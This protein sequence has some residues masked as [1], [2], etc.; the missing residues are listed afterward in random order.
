MTT[1]S[2][3]SM[4]APIG[5]QLLPDQRVGLRSRAVAYRVCCSQ[6]SVII[7]CMALGRADV[8]NAAVAMLNVVPLHESSRPG[9]VSSRSAKPLAG[10]SGRYL[11]V[12]N[13]DSA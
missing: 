13:S 2:G 10:N 9:R 7:P 5:L 6:N 11:A 8:T 12:R 3:F 1:L 4:T